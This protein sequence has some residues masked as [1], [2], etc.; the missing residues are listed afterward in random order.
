MAGDRLSGIDQKGGDPAQDRAG[1]GPA[2]RSESHGEHRRFQRRIRR[3]RAAIRNHPPLDL[4]WRAVVLVLGILIIAAGVAMLVLP[5]PGWAAIFVGLAVLS[6]E[7]DWA[8]RVL[9]RAR[10][11]MH[12]ARERAKDPRARRRILAVTLVAVVVSGAAAWW[13]VGRYG[14]ALPSWPLG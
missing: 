11:K 6:T 13:Y 10:R 14:Y 4:T 3:L 2:V 7:F 9:H 1:E 12:A 5:G 8:Q